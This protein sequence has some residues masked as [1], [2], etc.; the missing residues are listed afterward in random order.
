MRR[1]LRI[2]RIG[3]LGNQTIQYIAALGLARAI[4]DCDVVGHDLPLLRNQSP[5]IIA[6]RR[7]I[8]EIRGHLID[9]QF[10]ARIVERYDLRR[11]TFKALGHRCENYPPREELIEQFDIPPPPGVH[12]GDD[13]LVINVRGA[14]ILSDRHKDYGPVPVDFYVKLVEAVGKLPV[15]MGQIGTDWYSNAL[16]ER[17]PGAAFLPSLG[18]AGD[19]AA[20]ASARH[21]VVSLSSFSW[22]AAW[23]SQA[24]TIHVPVLGFYNP[25]Q[26]PDVNLLPVEDERYRFYRFPVREWNATAGDIAWLREPHN[27]YPQSSLEVSEQLARARDAVGSAAEAAHRFLRRRAI[28]AWLVERFV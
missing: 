3:N 18:P 17:F 21:V 1:R 2:V 5:R 20:I 14:E 15:F 25:A 7:G 26:R 13:D 22:V 6:P 23:L 19:F 8:F 9:P 16:R 24:S 11:I 28:A 4:G 27:Y 10:I 12:F